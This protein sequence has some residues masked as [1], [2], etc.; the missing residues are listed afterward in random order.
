I[1]GYFEQVGGQGFDGNCFVFDQRVA[2][3]P[4][5]APL[6]AKAMRAQDDPGPIR[7]P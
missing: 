4:D 7:R 3:D 6:A 2:L 5:L 1:L